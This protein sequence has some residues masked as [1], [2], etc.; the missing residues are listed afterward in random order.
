MVSQA[1]LLADVSE[2]IIIVTF[3][4]SILFTPVV[5]IYW[6]WWRHGIGRTV[7]AEALAMALV[8]VFPALHFWFGVNVKGAP[9]QWFE[10]A[11][12]AVVPAIFVWRAISIWQ[13]QRWGEAARDRPFSVRHPE[14][15]E[16]PEQAEQ[17]EP[18]P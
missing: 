3:C 11:C 14:S 12:F 7:I 15:P 1:R 16:R 8:F 2:I 5:S 4:T 18:A 13:V 10:L 6:P 9:H 17:A